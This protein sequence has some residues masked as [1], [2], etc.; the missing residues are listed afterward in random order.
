MKIK[1]SDIIWEL[2][3]YLKIGQTSQHEFNIWLNRP[4]AD[5]DVYD[6]WEKERTRSMRQHLVNGDILFDIGAEMGWLSVIYGQMVGPSNVVLIEPT[7]EFWPNIETLWHKNFDAEPLANYHGLFSDKTTDK[8]TLA[9]NEW[10]EASKDD[11]IDKLSY[12]YIHENPKQISEITLDDYVRQT[13]IVPNAITIDCE[14]AELLILH[15]ASETLKN[16]N[17]KVWVS[18]HPDLGLKDY[19]IKKGEIKTYMRQLGYDEEFLGVD[20]E[21]HLRFYKT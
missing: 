6:M 15:G 17:V 1:R 14:G 12:T 19:G 16:N 9:L 5:W 4:L 18:E 13:G 20:H 10:P 2:K 8:H 3:P 11:L 7:S 21:R